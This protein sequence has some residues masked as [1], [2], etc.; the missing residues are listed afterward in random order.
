MMKRMVII[1]FLLICN[2]ST[3]AQGWV[4]DD[5][6]KDSSD[7]VFTGIFG[8][9]LLL[10]LIWMSR[11]RVNDIKFFCF[12]K[13]VTVTLVTQNSFSET[14]ICYL[15]FVICTAKKRFRKLS[16]VKCNACE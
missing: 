15:L 11:G 3:F 4:T 5:A 14:V 12:L 8:V 9:L 10:G 1:Y 6:V 7:G 13:T 2:I 16:T